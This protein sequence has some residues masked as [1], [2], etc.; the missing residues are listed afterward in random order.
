MAEHELNK[1]VDD[2][3]EVFNLRDSTKQPTADR[4]TAWGSTPS[5]TK[6]P[7]EKLVKDSLDAKVSAREENVASVQ[8]LIQSVRAKPGGSVGSAYLTS[9]STVSGFSIPS[10]WY[11]YIW[12][13]HRNGSA[14]SD[15]QKYGTLILTPL[16]NTPDVYVIEG[17]N[18]TTS[19]PTYRAVKLA[20]NVDARTIS[21]D[22]SKGA[23]LVV[24][25][26]GRMSSNYN[27][28]NFLYVPTIASGGSAGSFGFSGTLECDEYISCDFNKKIVFSVDVKNLATQP[29]NCV[30]RIFVHEY[31]IDKKSVAAIN[32]M[33]GVGTLTELT[34]DLNPGDTVVHLAD[35]S[36]ANWLSTTNYHHGF[37]F[38]NYT[39]SYGYLYPPET[40]SRNVYPSSGDSVSLW[41]VENVN[42]SAGT[43]TL[44]NPWAGP[45][46]PAG[47]KVSRRQS[48]N[49][50]PYPASATISDTEWHTLKGSLQGIT[51]PGT[52]ERG[53]KFSQGTAFI[54]VG[55][56]PTNLTTA[57]ETIGKRAVFANL[58]M[59]EEQ[60]I[61][62]GFGTLPVNRGGTGKTSVTAGNYLLGNGTS[63][64]AEK[65]P[66]AAAND[67]IN[68]LST[69]EST[70]TDNDYYVA[71]Y[72]GGGTTTK[73]YHRRPVKA[74]WEYI[75]AKI[76]SVLG[77]TSSSYGGNAATATKATQDSDGNAINATYFKS[78]GNTTLV[79]GAAT[80]IGTQNGADVKL[81]LPAHQDI[82]GKMN[83][84]GDNAVAPSSSGG[85]GATATLLNNLTDGNGDISTSNGDDVLIVTTDNGG[86][87]TNK[88][89]KRKLVK[90][91]PW[92]I[93][94]L[95]TKLAYD[96]GAGSTSG[97][98]FDAALAAY[99][100]GQWV[101]I[102]DSSGNVY[103]CAGTYNSG[104]RFKRLTNSASG[105]SV[106]TLNWTRGSAPS[107][108][109]QLDA[110]LSGHT[111]TRSDITNF[112]HTHGNIQDGGSLQT[113][114]VTIASGDKL[115]IT[116]SSDSS[117]VA[118]A[119]ASFDGS[120]TTKAL[121]QKG[122]FETFMTP[123]AGNAASGALQ[124]LTAQLT[125]GTSD[126]TD[127]TELFSSYAGSDGFA[128]S[129]HVNQPYRRKASSMLNYVR[130]G[131]AVA[132]N[133]A[134]VGTAHKRIS[135]GYG[136][137]N[138]S[139]V[140]AATYLVHL[141]F[142]YVDDG[143][144]Q[145]K[146]ITVLVTYDFRKTGSQIATCKILADNGVG[147]AGYNVV[148]A[149]FYSDSGD[150]KKLHICIGLV[151]NSA[152][153]TLV[154]FSYSY[155]KIFKLC[156]I[157]DWTQ[158]ISS[159][160]VGT[161]DHIVQ[162]TDLV[163]SAT[164]ADMVDGKHIAFGV[165]AGSSDTIYFG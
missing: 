29:N 13:P 8:A 16:T 163:S 18:L 28:S 60:D 134:D 83:T 122:T 131:F 118:R 33:F 89:Y 50:Y 154:A 130:N 36:N 147:A 153:T 14:S 15:N 150:N 161:Y 151:K 72:A 1:I 102:H 77:L 85:D 71:Q 32:V 61:S 81:T 42:V 21:Q 111:H 62:D 39:N 143:G 6:Y 132:R 98:D 97:D 96:C 44:N 79:A 155:C 123:S 80:K 121:T 46:I 84:S 45:A 17:A 27:F 12:V 113:S 3:G 120:T 23:N 52:S 78:S 57:D 156:T 152:P 116:D 106:N 104:L 100:A 82:S 99:N 69:G 67:L 55:L 51:A 76:S 108:G 136:K 144:L 20:S 24:N 56:Y 63:A 7:S 88:W 107:A 25:G 124:N 48:G 109:S 49:T 145:G 164:N 115:V 87:I 101:I 70:P 58:A 140:G 41:E 34:Q 68:A 59:Y 35:L 26:S 127:G 31:D 95:G 75:K 73:T 94:K 112:A 40:Y 135:L 47:T 65:T 10:A 105:I 138:S 11:N 142:N 128:T 165:W 37:I 74:L 30:H 64:L 54:R 157:G 103:Y 158:D 22:V 129:G 110:S 9:A 5:D 137:Y 43:I 93:S 119:S 159:D 92:I 141:F 148:L 4:V 149:N 53:S 19:S 162:G 133:P 38:W 2:D 86:S 139:A 91:I 125:E 160:A 117:K 126:F 146:G 114:D 66:N 90:L